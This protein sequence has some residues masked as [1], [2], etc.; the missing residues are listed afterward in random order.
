MKSSNIVITLS[1]LL[2]IANNN[3]VTP[4]LKVMYFTP[5]I[6]KAASMNFELFSLTI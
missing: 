5:S 3:G 4:F 1:F 6:Y 2:L